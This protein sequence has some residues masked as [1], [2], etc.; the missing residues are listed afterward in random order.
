LGEE[1]MKKIEVMYVEFDVNEAQ[2]N[3]KI[4][5]GPEQI[6]FAHYLT[7]YDY[8]DTGIRH[9]TPP[10]IIDVDFL[11]EYVNEV[12]VVTD[13]VPLMIE[14]ELHPHSPQVHCVGKINEIIARKH[15]SYNSLICDLGDFG[16]IEV[17]LEGKFELMVGMRV[18]FTGILIVEF[19]E[20]LI[21]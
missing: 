15:S 1:K 20:K 19:D 9:F 10:K 16:N 13:E 17:V 4:I 14:H 12:D 7:N 5:G 6:I 18:E 3:L 8:S 2:I 21:C 11:I